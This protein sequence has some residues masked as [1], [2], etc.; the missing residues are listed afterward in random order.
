[1][2]NIVHIQPQDLVEKKVIGTKKIEV[3]KPKAFQ[4]EMDPIQEKQFLQ[5]EIEALQEQYQQL[6]IQIKQ[7]QETAKTEIEN[8]WLQQQEEAQLEARRLGDEASAQGFQAG[9]EQGILQAENEFQQKRQEMQALLETAYE[10]RK[11]IVQESEPFL[12]S[13]SVKIAEKIIKAEIN[14]HPEQLLEMVK[15]ALKK[16]E[17]KEDVVIQM[18]PEDY[19]EILPYINE[20]KTYVGHDSELKVIPVPNFTKG[21]CMIHTVSGSY[22]VTL[23]S[24]LE[25]IKQQLLAYCEGKINHDSGE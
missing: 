6:Q 17:E 8:W 18:S 20:L 7:E 1:M 13:L 5:R 21:G 9:Y 19:P 23:T 15:Q 3:K 22:D 10:E 16:V 24:Q 14:Q 25:E 11:Q 12:L 2:S 4:M